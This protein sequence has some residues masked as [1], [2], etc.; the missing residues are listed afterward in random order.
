MGTEGSD[1]WTAGGVTKQG[2]KCQR[3]NL[4]C[5]HVG[6]TVKYLLCCSS[7]E[8]FHWR[9]LERSGGRMGLRSKLG[10]RDGEERAEPPSHLPG[11]G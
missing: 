6:F 10:L 2:A 7:F 3:G 11:Q 5:R 1:M 4:G 8:N 9:S